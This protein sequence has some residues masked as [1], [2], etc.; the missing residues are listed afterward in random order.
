MKRVRLKVRVRVSP[1][2]HEKNGPEESRRT[3]V[4]AHR[5]MSGRNAEVLDN[6]CDAVRL[7]SAKFQ[8]RHIRWPTCCH[9]LT[10]LPFLHERTRTGTCSDTDADSG[11]GTGT[12]TGIGTGIRTGRGTDTGVIF[13]DCAAA[14]AFVMCP[15]I[16]NL[17]YVGSPVA[18]ACAVLVEC[19]A[20][21]EKF[22]SVEGLM[23]P[24]TLP[25]S[26]SRCWWRRLSQLRPLLQLCAKLQRPSRFIWCILKGPHGTAQGLSGPTSARNFPLA[27]DFC[28]AT[29]AVAFRRHA[30][31][32][33]CPPPQGPLRCQ[34]RA[35]ASLPE[36][37]PKMG[38]MI[39]WAARAM[40]KGT[41]LWGP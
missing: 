37:A 14:L 30:P 8:P 12:D 27:R 32:Q 36:R 24:P 35:A 15:L 29:T 6:P 13:N 19:G 18:W 20:G 11:T 9:R 16:R 31:T 38:R 4:R 26:A 17:L 2:Q 40:T 25:I 7:Q 10:A 3:K 41:Q 5:P 33:W 21:T 1:R 23:Y 28:T 39:R 22:I 34:P